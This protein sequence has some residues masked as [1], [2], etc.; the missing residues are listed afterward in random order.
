MTATLRPEQL[1]ELAVAITRLDVDLLDTEQ[2]H[3][4]LAAY[5][6][7][8]GGH[9]FT[10]RSLA[11]RI[12]W[13]SSRAETFLDRF[14][15]LE[16]DHLDR[17][18]GFRG[19]SLRRTVHAVTIG[20]Q[21]LYGWSAWDCLVLPVAVAAAAEV[22][23]TCPA[24]DRAITLGVTPEGV[25]RRDPDTAVL[26]LRAPHA[27][28]PERERGGFRALVHFLADDTAARSWA[29]QVADAVV[30]DLDDAFELARRAVHHAFPDV[31]AHRRRPPGA[32]EAP[33]P[34]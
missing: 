20:H 14:S 4:A 3:A 30:L 28:T 16:R 26:S 32:P 33:D 6:L 13:P 19:I 8:A 23:S 7:L 27:T 2:Q 29:E 11:E 5:G 12:D 25:R 22:R 18:I 24:T 10:A 21:V 17:V 9:A 1:D 34:R 31:L 15:R